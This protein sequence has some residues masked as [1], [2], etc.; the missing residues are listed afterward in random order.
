MTK[1][2]R[3][4]RAA[5]S[6]FRLCVTNGGVDEDRA[7]RIAHRLAASERRTALPLL[8]DFVRLVRLERSRRSALVE[9]A[10]PLPDAIQDRVRLDLARLYGAGVS[11]RFEA[12]PALIGG[13]RVMVGSDVYDGSVRARLAALERRL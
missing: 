13:M 3:I 2:K 9:S 12:N 1:S 7:R 4:K 11:A 10:A 5:R 6:L 8:S